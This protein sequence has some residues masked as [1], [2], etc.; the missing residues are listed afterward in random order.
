MIF[1]RVGDEELGEL[2]E[3]K[4]RKSIFTVSLNELDTQLQ[5]FWQFDDLPLC[6]QQN[7]EHE[8]VERMF[9]ESHY[10]DADGRFGVRIPMKP[11]INELGSSNQKA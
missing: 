2:K 10:R 8:L 3:H 7:R 4:T 5:R 6:V 1:G 9:Q 11:M